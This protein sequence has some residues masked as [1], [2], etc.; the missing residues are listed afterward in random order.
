MAQI[1]SKIILL[2]I[3]TTCIFSGT[4][5]AYVVTA[6]SQVLPSGCKVTLCGDIHM[7]SEANIPHVNSIITQCKQKDLTTGRPIRILFEQPSDIFGE[8]ACFLALFKTTWG[9]EVF[10]N[11]T[12]ENIEQRCVSCAAQYLLDPYTNISEIA[13]LSQQLYVNSC[14]RKCSMYSVTFQHVLEEFDFLKNKLKNLFATYEANGPIKALYQEKIELAGQKY[15]LLVQ[16]LKEH[17][18]PFD[19]TVRN[20]ILTKK[21]RPVYADKVDEL[22]TKTFSPLLDLFILHRILECQSSEDLIVIT[23]DDHTW[24]VQS[25][26]INLGATVIKQNFSINRQALTENE[27][28]LFHEPTQKSCSIL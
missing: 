10:N 19:Q 27:L 28:V 7:P 2:L 8:Q 6:I 20:I 3:L 18:F 13:E 1:P 21:Q 16:E 25:M 11:T 26:L 24:S 22:I 9:S 12:M 23:G 4:M 5:N 17:G 15:D 14:D